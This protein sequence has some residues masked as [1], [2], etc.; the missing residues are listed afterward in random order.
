MVASI[1]LSVSANALRTC[2]MYNS[3]E[4]SFDNIH[5]ICKTP[6][7]IT[8]YQLSLK[9]HKLLNEVPNERSLEHVAILDQMI[10][11][12]RQ[13]SVKTFKNNKSKIGLNTTA[14]KIYPLNGLISFDSL[15]LGFVHFKKLMKIQFLKNG[16]T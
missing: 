13:L 4:I 12:G 7:Q 11:T 3:N 2:M 1:G 15:N 6:K 14:N 16:N 9:L 8:L 5:K 10:C